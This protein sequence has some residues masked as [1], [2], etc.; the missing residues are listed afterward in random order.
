V[1]HNGT[2][3]N[4]NSGAAIATCP[5]TTTAST[6]ST[7]V[8]PTYVSSMPVDPSNVDYTVCKDAN[9]RITVSAP[10]AELDVTIS[11]TR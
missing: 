7:A 6:M 4:D 10:G 5:S 11:V 3:P 1:D 2:L 8:V 9:G